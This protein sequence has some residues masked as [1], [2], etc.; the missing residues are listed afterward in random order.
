MAIFLLTHL[1]EIGRLPVL[2][3]VCKKFVVVLQTPSLDGRR[4]TKNGQNMSHNSSS[5]GGCPK[6]PI[7][8]FEKSTTKL[9]HTPLSLKSR[10]I[11]P[12]PVRVNMLPMPVK[13][14]PILT[15]C[16][17]PKYNIAPAS[18]KNAGAPIATILPDNTISDSV[19][20]D[21]SAIPSPVAPSPSFCNTP[22]TT[23]VN[24]K[25]TSTSI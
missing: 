12:C 16:P 19:H 1:L 14:L 20:C 22:I 2:S 8:T 4:L 17:R 7:L 13:E 11:T 9:L 15:I 5:G 3:W 6:L 25:H 24:A 23:V 10:R 21:T 18:I